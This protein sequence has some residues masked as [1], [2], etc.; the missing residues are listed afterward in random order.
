MAAW[1]ETFGFRVKNS[2]G[3]QIPSV[4]APNTSDGAVVID[5]SVVSGGWQGFAYDIDNVVKT[6]NEQILKYR[7]IARQPEVDSA[8]VD[9]VNEMV[10]TDQDDYPVTLELDNLKIGEP[11]KKKFNQ[12]FQE[13]LDKLDFNSN[14]HDIC[15]KWYV[16][17]KIY[18]HI[19]LENTNVKNGIA[20]LRQIDPMKIKK[21]RN[22]K[23]VK[24]SRGVD[25][26]D[27]IEEYYIYNDK[28]INETSLQG[29]KLSADSMVM[30]HTGNIDSSTGQVIGYLSKAIKPANQLKMLEDAVVIHT[31]TRAPDRRVFY[32]DVGNLPKIKAEQYVTDIMNKFK[33]KLVYN[34]ATGEISDSKKSI[35]M[36]ED[37]WM[38]RRGDG[39]T[40]EITT[41]QG[42]QSL[43]GSE[44]VD[45]FQNKLYQSL[46]VPIGRMKPDTGFSLGR[47]SEITRDELKFNKFIGRL[48]IRFSALF[49]DL[50]RIQLIAKG[51]IRSD[52]W[53]DIKSKIR[54]DFQRDNH[55]TELKESEI[56]TGR[57]QTLQLVDPYLGKYV[58][59]K[60]VMK[61]ILRM[62]DN[63]ISDIDKEIKA[64]GEEAVPT[65]ISNQVTMMQIQQDAMQPQQDQEAA[66]ADDMHQQALSHKEDLHQQKLISKQND[67]N[68]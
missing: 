17:S 3:K 28:G 9:I 26:V 14:G 47:S 44:F 33:N 49:H 32:V 38:P 52:E 6:E 24:N 43:I 20:E 30:C 37:F 62:N 59:K 21:I 45:Y 35:S 16:D 66:Q 8:I 57:M 53:D 68:A 11:L 18:Y 56:L 27:S 55:F 63:E 40:T 23:K 41:L 31:I 4:I 36:I 51:L 22:V 29:I 46:N 19:L 5:T 13:I 48:R 58:S 65:E 39:K 67:N 12:A 10:V 34:A 25:V 1:Y 61:N 42:S 60:W 54:Y 64:E 50:M 2:D 15:R 7:D